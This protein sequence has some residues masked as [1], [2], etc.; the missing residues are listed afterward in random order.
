MP[1]RYGEDLISRPYSTDQLHE[2]QEQFVAAM[3]RVGY[4]ITAPSTAPGTKAA[5]AGYQRPD[6]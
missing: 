1:P 4:A 5:I 2:M 3:T 6:M